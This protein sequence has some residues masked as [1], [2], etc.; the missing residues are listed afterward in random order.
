VKKSEEKRLKAGR[1]GSQEA[2][3]PAANLT[4]QAFQLPSFKAL[5]SPVTRYLS[6]VSGLWQ[7]RGLDYKFQEKQFL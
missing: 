3:M 5:R 7:L 2:G 6:L 4:F 1:L